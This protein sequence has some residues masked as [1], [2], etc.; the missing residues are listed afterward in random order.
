VWY[1]LLTFYPDRP[2]GPLA[3]PGSID[4]STS[5]SLGVQ[6]RSSGH[7][8]FSFQSFDRTHVFNGICGSGPPPPH[9]LLSSFCIIFFVNAKDTVIVNVQVRMQIRIL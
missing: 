7:E 3:L 2:S 4:E 9:L 8:L 6:S 1:Y 5:P